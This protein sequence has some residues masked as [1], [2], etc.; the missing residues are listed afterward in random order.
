MVHG[1]QYSDANT[2]TFTTLKWHRHY[3]GHAV[4]RIEHETS[5][6]TPSTQT[7][8]QSCYDRLNKASW[9][10][11]HN[12]PHSFWVLRIAKATAH[13]PPCSQ[14]GRWGRLRRTHAASAVAAR[15]QGSE[16]RSRPPPR[17]RRGFAACRKDTRRTRS[18]RRDRIPCERM[19]C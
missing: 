10:L 7:V 11:N 16:S 4:C 5:T 3:F 8:L 1:H 14:G 9:R 18:L 17:C 13:P 2:N 6:K 19:G 15:S 12:L